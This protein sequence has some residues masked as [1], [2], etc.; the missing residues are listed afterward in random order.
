MRAPS[1]QCVVIIY[2]LLLECFTLDEL[3]RERGEVSARR[4]PCPLPAEHPSAPHPA[5]PLQAA[6]RAPSERQGQ[7]IVA[8]EGNSVRLGLTFPREP[9]QAGACV[10]LAF[11]LC[12]RRTQPS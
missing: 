5:S 11:V 10:V 12:F 1:L 7:F 4:C 2:Y 3:P 8:A 9:K 6:Q